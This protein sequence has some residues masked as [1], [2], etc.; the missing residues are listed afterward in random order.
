MFNNREL[1]FD[2]KE[3]LKGKYNYSDEFAELIA[4]TADT[5]IENYGIENEETILSALENCKFIIPSKKKGPKGSTLNTYESTSDVLEKE[6]MLKEHIKIDFAIKRSDNKSQWIFCTVPVIEYTGGE[7]KCTDVKN[8][9]VLPP[10]FNVNSFGSIGTLTHEADHVVKTFNNFYNIEGDKITERSGLKTCEYKLE[11]T[12]GVVRQNLVK[13]MGYGLEEALTVYDELSIM[14]RA[15][16]D[17]YD[18]QAYAFQRVVAG[19][20]LEDFGLGDI[21][22]HAQVTGEITEL[23]NIFDEYMPGGYEEFLKTLDESMD[24]EYERFDNLGDTEK[25]E[26]MIFKMEDH[27]ASEIAPKII[28]FKE[29]YTKGLNNSKTK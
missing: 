8:A 19:F 14:R 21:I 22:K 12:E 2:Y 27:F 29:N 4:I 16:D 28:A 10:N 5:L 15:Y 7:Y 11:Y 25:N 9:V 1:L 26:E 17:S 20:L 13:K 3:R 18:V 24:M 23:K 6:G